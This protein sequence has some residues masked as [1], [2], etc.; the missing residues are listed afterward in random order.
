MEEKKFLNVSEVA[1]RYG[2]ARVTIFAKAK[3]GE[4][5]AGIKIGRSRR[6]SVAEL[7]E[8]EKNLKGA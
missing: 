3:A 8:F 1:Q 4:F 7:E 5:P 6:W 2:L